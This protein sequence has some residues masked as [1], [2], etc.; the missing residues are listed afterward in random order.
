VSERMRPR[1][2]RH[3]VSLGLSCVLAVVVAPVIG[4][5]AGKTT[6]PE[7][8]QDCL[9]GPFVGI[10][11]TD[12]SGTVV[13][14]IDPGD[15]LCEPAETGMVPLHDG[16]G[17]EDSP[18]RSFGLCFRAANNPLRTGSM[19]FDIGLPRSGRTVVR[20]YAHVGGRFD[21]PF[22]VRTLVDRVFETGEHAVFWDGAD[23]RGRRLHDG[24]Y[25]AILTFESQSICGDV[26]VDL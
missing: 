20:I 9:R 24:I 25:R 8:L 7:G 13:G 5:C 16:Q 21:P 6:A 4:S 10:T 2:G 12:E 3:K 26:R 1:R 17:V 23:D 18:S 14:A 19:R 22:L 11:E 15:W